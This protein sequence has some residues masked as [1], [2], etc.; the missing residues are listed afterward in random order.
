MRRIVSTM[1]LLFV[2]LAGHA[3]VISGTKTLRHDDDYVFKHEG[4]LFFGHLPI[5]NIEEVAATSASFGYFDLGSAEILIPLPDYD[6]GTSAT[7]T[8][9]IF[10]VEMIYA[11]GTLPAVN[12]TITWNGEDS[13]F[14]ENDS[15]WPIDLCFIEFKVWAF[16]QGEVGV[17]PMDFGA[18]KSMFE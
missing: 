17:A 18:L 13:V 9:T 12:Y 15:N 11:E 14:F 6:D 8:E 3:E 5:G 7:L 4:P 10:T 2:G 16:R 1:I